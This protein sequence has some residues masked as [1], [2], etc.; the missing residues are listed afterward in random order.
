MT[1]SERILE[2]VGQLDE[3]RQRRILQFAESLTTAQSP[4][5]LDALLAMPLEDRTRALEAMLAHV[6][7][8]DYEYFEANDPIYD[9]IDDSNDQ[10]R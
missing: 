2:L 5:E 1:T 10:T 7:F 4:T 3:A 9:Y 8:D 6:S